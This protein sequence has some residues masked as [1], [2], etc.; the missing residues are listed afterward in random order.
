MAYKG[1]PLRRAHCSSECHQ[2]DHMKRSFVMIAVIG[3]LF[4]L[5]SCGKDSKDSAGVPSPV[6]TY[7]M[8]NNMCYSSTGQV[9]NNSFCTN[10][11]YYLNAGLCYNTS[12]Q[13]VAANLCN[14]TGGYN[15]GY[16]L[17]NGTCY[18]STGQVVNNSFCSTGNTGTISQVCNGTY[19]YCTNYGCQMGTCNGANCRGYTLYN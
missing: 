13:Q 17:N 1:C 12:G 19:Y 4:L 11:G 15:N 7:Y 16:T 18:N 2:G 9:V 3:A 6:V 14:N 5:A 8:S 10:A